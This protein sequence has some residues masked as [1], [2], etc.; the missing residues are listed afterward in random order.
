MS[1][2]T[3]SGVTLDMFCK[4]W[5]GGTSLNRVRQSAHYSPTVSTFPLNHS[6]SL[7]SYSYSSSSLRP[8]SRTRSGIGFSVTSSFKS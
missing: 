6:E 8:L 5:T 7:N 1:E 4:K 3:I 2:W